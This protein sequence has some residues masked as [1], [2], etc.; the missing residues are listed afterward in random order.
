M[1]D[2]TILPL[3]ARTAAPKHA[4]TDH[5]WRDCVDRLDHTYASMHK[6]LEHLSREL[7]AAR[8]MLAQKSEMAELGSVTSELAHRLQCQLAP[9]CLYLEALRTRAA[10]DPASLETIATVEAG[11]ASLGAA[12]DDLLYFAQP[13]A[14]VETWVS[15]ISLVD[16]ICKSLAARLLGCRVKV[17]LQIPARMQIVADRDMLRRAMTNLISNALDAMPHGGELVVT[18]YEGSREVEIEI[19]DSG[20][21]LATSAQRVFEPFYTTRH[22]ATGLGL[23]IVKGVARAHGGNVTA[24]NC[25]EGGAAFTIHLPRRALK[26]V[27]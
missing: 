27:A 12:L 16:D 8:D 9:L 3:S 21:G 15:P 4:A 26:A 5:V 24:C 6:Q 10:D 17:D 1:E 20:P 22:H 11:V 23:A 14:P 25:P 13:R 18:A 2:P 7:A 19:A